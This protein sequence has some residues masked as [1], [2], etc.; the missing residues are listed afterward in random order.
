ML[1]MAVLA[2]L[3][4]VALLDRLRVGAGAVDRY[5]V[6]TRSI[7]SRVITRTEVVLA[8]GKGVKRLV[9]LTVAVLGLRGGNIDLRRYHGNGE[10]RNKERDISWGIVGGCSRQPVLPRFG[11]GRILVVHA[12]G[13]L[14]EACDLMCTTDVVD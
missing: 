8:G 7:S 3:N 12:E 5:S 6:Y 2:M 10:G 14:V 13:L 1:P 11:P 4:G 9:G